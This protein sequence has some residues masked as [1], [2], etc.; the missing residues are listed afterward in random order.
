MG[1]VDLQE[2][3]HELAE[4]LRPGQGAEVETGSLFLLFLAKQVQQETEPLMVSSGPKEFLI[5]FVRCAQAS[6]W[7]TGVVLL[8]QYL[9]ILMSSLKSHHLKKKKGIEKERN[10]I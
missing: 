9:M 6:T 10:K 7:N 3:G 5:C 2:K 4:K 8:F 1:H